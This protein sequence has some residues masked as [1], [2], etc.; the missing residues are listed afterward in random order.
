M[1]EHKTDH[2][3]IPRPLQRLK[4]ITLTRQ[5]LINEIDHTYRRLLRMLPAIIKRVGGGPVE[6]TLRE[7][8]GMNG[9]IRSRLG[10]VATEH[11]LPPGACTC[12]EAEAMVENLRHSDR[13][14]QTWSDRSAAV[15]EALIGVRAFLIRRWSM[16][17]GSLMPA[18]L[19][20]LRNEARALQTQEA[21]L[22]RELI[23]LVHQGDRRRDPG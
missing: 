14:A 10:E 3:S 5:T 6:K 22:H 1:H 15:L 4:E 20:D 23:D 17:I 2:S 16:L 21:E 9:I 8:D 19:Q 7:Q 13:A 12:E 11:G 18:D